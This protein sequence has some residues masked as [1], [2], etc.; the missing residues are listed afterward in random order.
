MSDFLHVLIAGRLAGILSQKE[1]GSLAFS[2]DTGYAG[3]P[4]SLFMPISNRTYGDKAVRPYLFGLLPDSLDVRRSIGRE[5]GV[6]GNNPFALLRHIGLDCPGAVQLCDENSLAIALSRKEVLREIS[7]AE[8]ASR[9]SVGR[10]NLSARWETESE[11]WSLGGQQPKLALRREGD[12][13]FSCEGSAATTHILKPGIRNLQLEALNEFIC[14][15]LAKACGIPSSEVDYLCFEDEP[16]IVVTRYDRVYDSSGSVVRL[17]QEDFCQTL[18]VLP[19][20]KYPEEGGPG[21][22]DIIEVLKRTGGA[23]AD[24]LASFVSMLFFNYLIAA[25]D[26]HGK[27]YSLLLDK[28][29]AYLAPLYDVAS[30]LPYVQRP[31]D[32]KTAMGIAGENRVGKISARRLEKFVENNGLEEYGLGRDALVRCLENLATTIP[33]K[34]EELLGRYA[35]IAGADELGSR[36]MPAMSTLCDR[37]A[38]RLTGN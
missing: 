23:A 32:V 24:N 21:A 35:R 17:H 22:S 19:E 30:I 26:A 7:D 27:N 25:P 31:F 1:D 4:L 14:I 12:T 38:A 20:N 29:I 13:W 3:I 34:L 37:S 5:Y 15:K 9:L 2:Y 10:S 8:I 28:D 18:G 36:M 33:G 6:S 11:H 16:A